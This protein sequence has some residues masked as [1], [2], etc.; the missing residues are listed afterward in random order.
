MST[1]TT[2]SDVTRS[3]AW[4]LMLDLERQMRYYGKLGDR[5]LLRY[6]AIRY[7]L[8]F[9][10]LAEGAII[11]LLAEHPPY[12]WTLGG[13]VGLIIGFVT[14]FDAS[15]N[16]AEISAQLR[17][18]RLSL[19]DLLMDAESLWRDIEAQRIGDDEAERIYRT[20][21][22]QWSRATRVIT[23]EIHGPDNS[24]A[25]R[26]AYESIAERYGRQAR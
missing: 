8:L 7:I 26:E 16:Y 13:L 1:D 15:T 25:A 17:S 10:I 2:V 21:V 3:S 23:V 20:I 14:I 9:G 19:D 4:D 6:R 5:Y 11:L 12:L 18:T 22:N 24:Q